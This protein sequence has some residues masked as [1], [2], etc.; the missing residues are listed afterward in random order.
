MHASL[1]AGADPTKLIEDL[2]KRK[3]VK[4]LGVSMGQGQELIA[5]RLLAAAVAEGQWLLLQNTHLSLAY[6]AEVGPFEA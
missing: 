4:T 1:C 6:L 2:A 3:K 5:R